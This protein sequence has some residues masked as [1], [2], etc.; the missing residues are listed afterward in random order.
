M[1][2]LEVIER[3]QTDR[4]ELQLQ[5]RDE[6]Y[7]IISNGVFLM[8]S[9]NGESERLLIRVAMDAVDH[10]K[11][12]LVGGLG[13]GYSAAEALNYPVEHVTVVEIEEKIISWYLNYFRELTNQSDTDKRLSIVNDDLVNWISMTNSQFDV[14][15]LDTD[16]GPDWLVKDENSFLYSEK[17]ILKIKSILSQK[18][19]I[20]F[21][22]ASKS[23]QLEDRLS[24]FF[25]KVELHY[26]EQKRGEPDFVYVAY[27]G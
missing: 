17:G 21:W 1:S 23:E 10:P 11:S 13:I 25:K 26:V 20:A 22:S 3:I 19:C 9:M 24:K 5:I 18:G 4:G 15:C 6:N 12:V 16:N 7:E 2:S 8:S 14:I 27:Q